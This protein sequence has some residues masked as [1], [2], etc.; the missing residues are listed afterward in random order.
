MI[1]LNQRDLKYWPFRATNSSNKKVGV[2][3][4]LSSL[5]KKDSIRSLL[6]L[7]K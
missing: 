6:S 2:K 7:K 1:N 3:K 4:K 5:F